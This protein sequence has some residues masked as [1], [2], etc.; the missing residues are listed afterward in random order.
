MLCY[1]VQEMFESNDSLDTKIKSLLDQGEQRIANGARS[2]VTTQ[3][4]RTLDDVSARWEALKLRFIEHG[5]Q[6]T[7][8]CDEAKQLNDLLTTTMSW[9][10]EV[11]QTLSSLAPVSRLMNNIQ[12]QIQ[13]HQV[14]APVQMTFLSV[15]L[16]QHHL[17]FPSENDSNCISCLSLIN[18]CFS[19]W[20]FW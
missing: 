7:A 5:N 19:M 12:L 13:Q 8:A 2:D 4:R 10:N 17:C 15:F 14:T 6:L 20:S 11:E 18:Y 16:P 9:L 3:L 1:D